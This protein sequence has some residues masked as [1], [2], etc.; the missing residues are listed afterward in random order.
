M[1]EKLIVDLAIPPDE[2][3]RYYRGEAQTAVARARDGRWIRF[4]VR[5]LRGVVTQ[6]GVHGTF[7]LHVDG[8]RLIRVVREPARR[9][10]A[11]AKPS[12]R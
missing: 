10:A 8:N 2:L 7:V 9:K 1:T 3:A 6:D 11:A 12:R 4:P 5:V